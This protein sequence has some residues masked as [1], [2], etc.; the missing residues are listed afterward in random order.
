MVVIY[1]IIKKEIILNVDIS[2]SNPLNQLFASKDKPKIRL[3]FIILMKNIFNNNGILNYK[4]IISEWLRQYL[5]C[6]HHLHNKL[7]I[8]PRREIRC[9]TSKHI[10]KDEEI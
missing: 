10:L 3:F 1:V 9:L 6:L 2:D 7:T 5:F 8:I 4:Y